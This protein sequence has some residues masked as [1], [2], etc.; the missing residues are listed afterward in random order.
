MDSLC[1]SWPWNTSGPMSTW[2]NGVPFGVLQEPRSTAGQAHVTIMNEV[3]PLLPY[4]ERE[5]ELPHAELLTADLF[6]AHTTSLAPESQWAAVRQQ[7]AQ[8][9]RLS[10]AVLGVSATSGGGA[11]DPWD[12]LDL[13]PN[14]TGV[15][16]V[17]R[18][19]S[20]TRCLADYLAEALTVPVH[21]SVWY[22][23]A[24][25]AEY[26]AHC[27]STFLPPHPPNLVLLEFTPNIWGGNPSKVV[28]MVN[29]VAPGA[30]VMFVVWPSMGQW[31]SYKSNVDLRG[32]SAVAAVECSWTY[33]RS[34]VWSSDS[35]RR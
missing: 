15:G 28:Q 11:G 33:L 18:E 16:K 24:V 13:N 22:K 17:K 26:Y 3:L 31:Q 30:V 34:W 29:R 14:I 2:S 8:K 27:T 23:N 21:M 7:V 19:R 10:V 35:S 12:L 1:A 20:W 25:N 5:R 6:D 4:P 32:A 9:R